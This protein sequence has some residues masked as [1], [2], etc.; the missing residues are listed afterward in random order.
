MSS[1]GG[2]ENFDLN[3]HFENLVER[4]KGLKKI[5]GRKGGKRKKIWVKKQ[6]K[7]KG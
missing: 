2:N 7:K 3:Q 6:T 5:I 1:F 4:A